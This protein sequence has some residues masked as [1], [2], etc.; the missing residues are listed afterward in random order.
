MGGVAT[1]YMDAR[2]VSHLKVQMRGV[3]L[4][5]SAHASYGFA[6]VNQGAMCCKTFVEVGIHGE[7]NV[8]LQVTMGENE[9][10]PPA[11]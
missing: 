3:V 8:A 4:V 6:H 5:G 10:F 1:A 11:W 7:E 9:C 2:A